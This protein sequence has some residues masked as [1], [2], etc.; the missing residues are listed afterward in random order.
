MGSLWAHTGTVG[1]IVSILG[2]IINLVHGFSWSIKGSTGDS[3][4]ATLNSDQ[5]SLHV[6]QY[7]KAATF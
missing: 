5:V 3:E 7:P 6:I 1:C 2:V 4:V